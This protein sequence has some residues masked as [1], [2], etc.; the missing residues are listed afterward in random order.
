MSNPEPPTVPSTETSITPVVIGFIFVAIVVTSLLNYYG[1]RKTC[2]W[3]A[4]IVVLLG[5]LGPFSIVYFLPLDLS[6]TLYRRCPSDASPGSCPTP[7]SYVSEFFQLKVWQIIYW[8]LF[9]LTWFIIPIMQ[10]YL[11]C[12]GFTVIQKFRKAVKYNVWYYVTVGAI[13][14]VFLIYIAIARGLMDFKSIRA[15]VMALSNAYGLLLVVLFMGYGLV[16]VPRALWYTADTRLCL[17]Y[18]EFKAPKAKEA[19]ENAQVR[20]ENVGKEI[21][22]LSRRVKPHEEL[23]K[24]VDIMLLKC[25][26]NIQQQAIGGGNAGPAVTLKH[27]MQVHREMKRAYRE[28][29]R[30]QDQYNSL[31]RKAYHYQ[32]II[33]NEDSTDRKFHSTLRPPSGSKFIDMKLA[34]EWF[35]YIYLQ[36]LSLRVL[37]VGCGLL[38]IALL[39][40]EITMNITSPMLSIFG[41]LVQDKNIGYGETELICIVAI[42]YMCICTYSS[43]MKLRLFNFYSLAPN[44]H[45]DENSL[46]FC[47]AYLTRL[48]FPLCYNFL[49][50]AL[51]NETTFSKIM[52]TVN[53]VPLLGEQ[54]NNWIPITMVVI[55]VMT[56][57]NVYGR[58]LRICGVKNT[59]LY[60]E[61]D[62]DDGDIE[63]GRALITQARQLEERSILGH[64]RTTLNRTANRPGAVAPI[65]PDIIASSNPR[66]PQ[67]ATGS[68][69]PSSFFRRNGEKKASKFPD[70]VPILRD[71]NDE[72]LEIK[73]LDESIESTVGGSRSRGTGAAAKFTEKEESDR[74]DLFTFKKSGNPNRSPAGINTGSNNAD[75]QPAPSRFGFGAFAKKPT[76]NPAESSSQTQPV[77]INAKS[78]PAVSGLGA[79]LS[80]AEEAK[81]N[82]LSA[83]WNI[84][85]SF[86]NKRQTGPTGSASGNSVVAAET[87]KTTS[88]DSSPASLHSL[89]ATK[90]G[91]NRSRSESHMRKPS[92]GSKLSS[93]D[94]GLGA[95]KAAN[96]GPSNVQGRAQPPEVAPQRGRKPR[97]PVNQDFFSDI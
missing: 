90:M 50:L 64:T 76:A 22:N 94:S 49:N 35:W 27:I 60:D 82:L 17:K 5:W 40:S 86:N 73:T 80:R 68:S 63:D 47:A 20:V 58:I 28:R 62:E 87:L 45:T 13:G 91:H 46:L 4:Q 42:S 24:Y 19:V 12:G 33:E 95:L 15:F 72:L 21:L 26:L 2:P 56:V 18:L 32:D 92:G 77:S 97:M 69:A 57:G 23:R 85:S 8:T 59:F 9:C 44:H 1:N 74:Q 65:N 7:F 71:S 53:L 30:C 11:D 75:T 37:A 31:L 39:W 14:I 66:N 70:E 67:N 41:L 81:Q 36:P 51:E 93:D 78:N 6:S 43:L 10:S 52:G 25:P 88:R 89:H 55:C 83:S 79:N 84:S 16:E 48:T 38:S 29:D 54:F 34:I 3:Y 96:A 61:E